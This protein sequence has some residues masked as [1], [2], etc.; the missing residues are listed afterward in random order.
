MNW[1][2]GDKA[3]CIKSGTRTKAGLTY[4]VASVHPRGSMS[5]GQYF[6]P[7]VDG[8]RF[9]EDVHPNL[10]SVSNHRRFIKVDPNAK[11]IERRVEQKEPA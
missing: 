7:L 2:P 8:L 5:L 11:E 4:T 9:A 10:A 1:N 3:L 6:W